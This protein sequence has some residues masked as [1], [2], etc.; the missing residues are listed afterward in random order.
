MAGTE[1]TPD[2]ASR[3]ASFHDVP[4]ANASSSPHP[5]QRD[6]TP[7]RDADI[8]LEDGNLVLIAGDTAF[9]VHKSQLSRHSDVFNG[10]LGMPQHLVDDVIPPSL[11]DMCDGCTVIHLS[12]TA[13]DI[14]RLLHALYDG[15]RH[16][17][18]AGAMPFSEV[19]ALARMAHKYQ[20][21]WLLQESTRRLKTA[22][23]DHFALWPEDTST[24]AV[25]VDPRDAIEAFN[26]FRRIDR[27]DMLPAA[28]Y[29]CCQL[30]LGVL[31]RGVLR[32]DSVSV[33]NL[34]TD[35]LERCLT[36]RRALT[37]SNVKLALTL[38]SGELSATC[39]PEAKCGQFFGD[40]HS[41]E[42][43]E[44]FYGA[45]AN[46]LGPYFSDLIE[47][48]LGDEPAICQGCAE[49]LKD[50]ERAARLEAWCSLPRYAGVHLEG[51][52]VA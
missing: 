23:P 44:Y 3:D 2:S 20:I 8:W 7:S 33:E 17:S 39:P 16:V 30:D 18:P 10:L 26:L 15:A 13:Y 22:F 35:D 51:W 32:A 4:D 41:C 14:K 52:G 42:M 5:L 27:P 25:T 48:F 29:A 24:P 11:A 34:P 19:A 28:L 36:A 1:A 31:V 47:S 45:D 40:C 50:R 46:I 21:D 9:R 38:V 12:D 49:M 43:Q 6:P 37:T